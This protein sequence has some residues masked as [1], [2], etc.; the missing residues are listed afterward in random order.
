MNEYPTILAA[1]RELQN[2]RRLALEPSALRAPD[3]LSAPRALEPDGRHLA[4]ALYRIAQAPGPDGSPDPEAVYAR[5]AG[6]VS[7]L[8]GVRRGRGGPGAR[9]A[10][11]RPR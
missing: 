11:P 10:H 6:R 5:V 4:A 3:D 1:R 2:W 7:D 8:S 9:G